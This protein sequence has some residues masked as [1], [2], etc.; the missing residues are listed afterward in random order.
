MEKNTRNV[1]IV[2][3]VL[4]FSAW[5]IP[6]LFGIIQPPQP[7]SVAVT[8]SLYITG[9]NTPVSSGTVTIF[10]GATPQASDSVSAGAWDAKLNPGD[11][12]AAF[13]GSG[14]Y[15]SVWSF[16]VPKN[17]WNFGAG[18][19][20]VYAIAATYSITFSNETYT[21]ASKTDLAQ[22]DAAWKEGTVTHT[23]G[24]TVANTDPYTSFGLP[25][26]VN[27]PGRDVVTNYIVLIFDTSNVNCPEAEES[28]PTSTGV[29]FLLPWSAAIAGATTGSSTR[30]ITLEFTTAGSYVGQLYLGYYTNKAECEDHKG[31]A[32]PSGF[33][34]AS[35]QFGTSVAITIS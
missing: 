7:G 30:S 10:S 19:H 5:V 32:A 8:G 2:L 33:T 26:A 17:V 28:I 1:I 21:L 22:T 31:L 16:N 3:A 25:D 20:G 18:A 14:V 13:E 35:F 27:Y 11:Y 24:I 15:T 9:N 4:G 23:Y 34:V 12:S 29:V 6:T